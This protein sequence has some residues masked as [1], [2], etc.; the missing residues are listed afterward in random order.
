MQLLR[1]LIAG[2]VRN[3]VLVNLLMVCMV[4]GGFLSA[5]GMVREAYPEFAL[6]LVTVEVLYPGASAKDVER[7]VCTPI[8]EVLQG[9]PGVQE[10]S[11]SAHENFGT[12]WVSLHHNVTDVQMILDEVKD[13]VEQIRTF[14]PDV[15]KPIIHKSVIR[16]PVINVAIHGDISERSLKR[17]AQD[18]QDDFDA[19][20]AVSQISLSGVR[21]DEII[22]ELSEEALSAY[23]LSIAHVMAVVAKSTLDLPAGVIRTADEEFTLRVTGQRFAAREYEDLVVLEHRDTIVRLGDIASIRE[24]FAE[25]VVRGRF[26]GEPAVVVQ[27]FKTPEEDATAIAAAVRDYV[28]KRQAFLP[29]RLKMAVWA[30]ASRE[31]DQRIA[32]LVENG[33]W[34][35]GLVFVTLL[36]FIDMRTA[37]WVGVG[38]P[39]SFGGALIIMHAYGQT[40]NLISLFS[41]IMVTGI[42]VDDAIVIAES[43]HAR[44]RAGDD[45]SL[46]AVNGAHRVA[47]P[48]LGASLTTVAAFMPLLYVVGVMGRLI[49]VLPVV[50]IAAIVASAIEAFG[51]LPSHLTRREAVGVKTGPRAPGRFRR[52]VDGGI[53]R[54]IEGAYRPLYRLAMC[55]RV[56]TVAAAGGMFLLIVGLV[57]GGRAPFVLLPREN[58]NVLRTRI[59]FPEGTPAT[60][61][62]RAIGRVE[63]AALKLND[64]PQLVPAAKGDLVRQRY[65]ILGEFA[66]FMS[67]RG[68]NLCEVRIELMPAEDRRLPDE[69][70]IDR[71]RE[72]IGVIDD[73]TQ[74]IVGRQP[75]GPMEDPLEIRLLGYDLEDLSEASQRI[76]TKLAEFEGLHDIRDDL[77][78]G[79]RE[80]HVTLKPHARALGLTLDDVAK[81]LRY[82]FYGGEALRLQRG[83][84]LVKVRVRLPAEERRSI[85][86]LERIRIKTPRGGEVPF[87]EVADVAWARGYAFIMHQDGKRRVRVVADVDDRRANA[88]QVLQS[89]EAGFLGEVVADYDDMIYRFGGNRE[90]MTE[91][92]DSL[93][94]GFIMAV[95]VIYAVLAGMLRSYAQPVVILAAVPLGLIGVVAGHSL[96]GFDLTIMSLFGAVAL[97]GVVVNDSL[98]LLD[99][100]NVHIREGSGVRDSIHRAGEDR[101]RAVTLTSLTTVAGLLPILLERSSQAQAVKPMAVALSFGLIFSTV[102]TLFVVPALYLLLNDVRRFAHWLRYGGSYPVPEVVEEAARD[103]LLAAG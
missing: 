31:I 91:S 90:R 61:T 37:F 70:I 26:N 84:D 71:W 52:A 47:L 35:I 25:E 92:L 1:G 8:E 94:A 57:A 24:G 46:A 2:G 22:I 41:L 99:G 30:D 17:L 16:S 66:D 87:L 3:P 29:D 82:G 40:L 68:N 65:S 72:H 21:D 49:H 81:Q 80:L 79:K 45:P 44:R 51:I 5:R 55:Y 56:V 78:P 42:I 43:I 15:E 74:V 36:L 62:E 7:A 75:V 85:T 73:A 23:N 6:D 14:P 93:V 63:Q 67:I 18:V 11:S 58:V 4:V 88:E 59:R 53:A 38:I 64:D 76:Q 34:G 83:R 103:R 32:M 28:E 39:V 77:I 9:I 97:S 95:V 27:V 101:F 60:V 54:F 86:D 12:V 89:L 10:I 33:A 19:M 13:R 48:V 102:L 98:V 50:V 100:V 69:V 96:L 20:P